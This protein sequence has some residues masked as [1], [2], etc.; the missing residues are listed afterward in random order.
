MEGFS[1][2]HPGVNEKV[3]DALRK[4]ISL[5]GLR[6]LTNKTFRSYKDYSPANAS[7]KTLKD[8]VGEVSLV[9]FIPRQTECSASFF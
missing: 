4:T 7:T 1:Q 6:I 9:G 8:D 2:Q 5:N 3:I